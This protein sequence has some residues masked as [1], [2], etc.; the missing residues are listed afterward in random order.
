M[1]SKRR[2]ILDIFIASRLWS[3]TDLAMNDVYCQICCIFSEFTFANHYEICQGLQMCF[4]FSFVF[5]STIKCNQI[6]HLSHTGADTVAVVAFE[7]GGG[8][9]GGGVSDH[10]VIDKVVVPG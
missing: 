6:E 5:S 8:E 2:K 9:V 4:L 7:L 1:S 10:V 3:I